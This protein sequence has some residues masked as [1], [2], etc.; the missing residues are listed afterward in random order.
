VFLEFAPDIIVHANHRM[1][2]A[3]EILHRL[4]PISPLL[5]VISVVVIRERKSP[6]SSVLGALHLCEPQNGERRILGAGG[7]GID[8]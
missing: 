1:P 7:G 3:V 4:D 8:H 2:L 5:P 6:Q